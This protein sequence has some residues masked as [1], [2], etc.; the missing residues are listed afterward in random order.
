MYN[1]ITLIGKLTAGKRTEGP[2]TVPELFV[3]FNYSAAY[4]A[5]APS[6]PVDLVT[7]APEM[8]DKT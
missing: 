4:Q 3:A 8:T 1:R 7:L 2:A 6:V 5:R